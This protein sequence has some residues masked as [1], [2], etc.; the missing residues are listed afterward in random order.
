MKNNNNT[1]KLKVF[2]VPLILVIILWIILFLPAGT[3]I[4][5]EAWIFWLGFS[6]I[7]FFI[8]VYFTK[9]DP[10]LLSRRT[11]VRE[12]ETTNK[13]PAFLKAYYLGFILPGIDFRFH[14]SNEPIWLIIISNIIAFAAYI[15]SLLFLRKI[16][17][18]QLLFK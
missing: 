2:M 9:K 13:A 5:W 18:L 16:V 15:L 1:S 11:K 8:A 12:K 3:I 14:W 6:F 10:E 4:F 7:T 17:M